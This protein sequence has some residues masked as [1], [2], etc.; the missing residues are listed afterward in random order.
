MSVANVI[1]N[2]WAFI[3][4]G[5]SCAEEDA[6]K[7][8]D[9]VLLLFLVCGTN[10]RCVMGKLN[11]AVLRYLT[12]EDFRVLTAVGRNMINIIYVNFA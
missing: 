9:I 7:S 3:I 2:L 12:N 5:S 1:Y 10:S 8:V 4:C 6:L 11:V